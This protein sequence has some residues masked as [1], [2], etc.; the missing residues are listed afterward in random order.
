MDM[1]R[2]FGVFSRRTEAKALPPKPL[3]DAF[4]NRVLMALRDSLGESQRLDSFWPEIHKKLQY[5]HGTPQLSPGNPRTPMMDSIGFLLACDDSSFLD[6]IEYALESYW[7]LDFPGKVV[8]DLNQF[9]LVDD[10]PY[11]I[12]GYVWTDT[13]E[14]NRHGGKQKVSNLTAHPQVIVRGSQVTH[15]LAIEPALTLLKRPEFVAANTEF[16]DGL[17]DYR[18]GDY[19]DCLTKC[20]SAF[21]SV[22]KVICHRNS[23]PYDPKDTADPLLKT[24]FAHKPTLEPFLKE[25]LMIVATLRNRLSKS[26]GAGTTPKTVPPNRAEYTINATAAAILLLVS[27]CA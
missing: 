14:T 13:I 11:A 16:L 21:E 19:G 7:H 17:S 18:K 23:W 8:D 26:H 10:L 25:P 20:G 15:A 24:V 9:L 3:T 22:L 4:R 6:F 5:L 1:T 12:T 2:V 27:E